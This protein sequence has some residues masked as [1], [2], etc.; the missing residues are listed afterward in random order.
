MVNVGKYASPIDPMETLSETQLEVDSSGWNFSSA[1]GWNQQ[2][3]VRWKWPQG[4]RDIFG[5]CK[6]WQ[7]CRKE[8]GQ[9]ASIILQTNFFSKTYR[10]KTS[11]TNYDNATKQVKVSRPLFNVLGK[12][13]RMRA[14][15]GDA[16]QN[17]MK[18]VNYAHWKIDMRIL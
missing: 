12:V 2:T 3:A 16:C 6:F 14:V 10:R 4:F 15:S 1:F 8:S 5:L 18:E 17:S 11:C 13:G 7:K 9:K